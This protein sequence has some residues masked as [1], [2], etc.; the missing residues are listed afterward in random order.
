MLAESMFDQGHLTLMKKAL[1]AYALRHKVVSDN[2]ANVDTEGFR[3]RMVDFEA[4]LSEAGRSA[5]PMR[6]LRT[7]PGHLPIGST[8]D[9]KGPEVRS[10][11]AGF[12]NGVNDVDVDREM[13]EMVKNHLAYRLA[14]R[15][16]SRKYEGLH[17]AITGTVR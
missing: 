8:P 7:D 17:T 4:A 12:D 14:T 13:G 16:L 3:S 11:D 5:R 15:L 1:S 9:P 2:L 10:V 6:G